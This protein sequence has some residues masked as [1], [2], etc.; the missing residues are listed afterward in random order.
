[1]KILDLTEELLRSLKVREMER[2]DLGDNFIET[3]GQLYLNSQYKKAVINKNDEVVM[4][5][6]GMIEGK[7]AH[8]WIIASDL[9]YLNPIESLEIIMKLEKEAIEMHQVKLLYTFNSPD[10]PLAIR[11]LE[12]IGYTQKGSFDNFPDGKE[13]IILIKEVL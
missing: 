2:V 1:M 8:V 13:R 3:H 6:G 10:F 12:R 7:K 11:F 9:I 4:C 5:M